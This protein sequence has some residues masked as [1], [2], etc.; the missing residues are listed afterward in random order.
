ML[1]DTKTGAQHTPSMDSH[2]RPLGDYFRQVARAGVLLVWTLVFC[3]ASFT[4]RAVLQFDVFLGYDGVVP[5]A[6]WFPVVCEIKND[7]PPFVGT[8]EVSSANY[9]PGQTCR[10]VVELPTGTLKRI[11]LPVFCTSRNF[12][13]WD[14]RLFDERG[15]VRAEQPGLRPR[16]LI[17]A[18]TLLLGAMPRTANGAPV[19]RQILPRNSELQ[20]ATARMLPAIFPDNP[21]ILEGMDALYLNSEKASDLSVS[22][23]KALYDW[24]RAGGHLIVA[25]EQVA[26]VNGTPWLKSIF[27]GDLKGMQTV[28]SHPELQGWLKS[29]TWRTNLV[30]PLNA[31]PMP[32]GTGRNRA[33]VR[34]EAGGADNPF[35]DLPDD[36][37]FE[38]AELQVASC[39]VHDGSVVVAAENTPLV[40]TAPRGRGRVTA[41]LFSPEREPVRSWKNLPTFWA[42]VTDVPG[43]LYLSADYN[44]MGG[45]SSDGVFGAMLDTRQVHKLPV[46]WLLLLLI[47]Y[48]IVIGPFDQFWLKRIGRPM[49]TWI[50]F[51]CYVVFFSLLI[52]FI[53][54]KLRAGESEWNE[55]HVVDVLRSGERAELRGRTYAS[56]YSPSNQRYLLE[57]QQQF[58]SLRGEFVGNW[59]GQSTEKASVLQTGDN[60]KAE[61]FVPVWTSQLFVND[62]WQQ[63]NAP[64]TVSVSPQGADWLVTIE[65]RT[66]HKLNNVQV[67]LGGFIIPFGDGTVGPNELKPLTL[68][69]RQGTTVRDFVWKYGSGFQNA[70]T[71]RQH[72]FG[73][74]ESGRIDD[75]PNASMAAS[76][77]SELGHQQN[78]MHFIA[79]PGLDLCSTVEHGTAMV[80]AWAPGYSPAKPLYQFTPKRRHADTLWRV[81]AEIKSPAPAPA[82]PAA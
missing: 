66:E 53:G 38:A 21:L 49:L 11:Y 48:L 75:L 19:L 40:V 57:G 78:Y 70:V 16:K 68:S 7:G 79:P 54:Y 67:V 8:I 77:I 10:E 20:P 22:Q 23:V 9:N 71:S 44:Q 64:L 37:S 28:K 14:V 42:K 51:P 6:S 74:T 69:R 43:L 47:V 50:T 59:G 27:P 33:V 72:A 17:A 26:D 65:N 55:L 34:P 46:E 35:S 81:A 24:L 2:R 63:A 31:P 12:G 73:A 25:V 29:P 5:E 15:R 18:D 61:I 30:Q 32:Y 36:F 1:A 41:L 4:A 13:N 58:A 82:K 52:Y 56:V 39:A 62:W 76:F 45:W 80:L 3:G 60:F